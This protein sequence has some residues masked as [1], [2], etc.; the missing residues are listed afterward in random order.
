MASFGPLVSLRTAPIRLVGPATDMAHSTCTLTD[1]FH[2]KRAQHHNTIAAHEL[3]A[4]AGGPWIS[5]YAL[6]SK[7]L[8]A[9]RR[10]AS[11]SFGRSAGRGSILRPLRTMD[12][13]RLQ[14]R[15]NRISA[16]G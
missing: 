4:C 5:F 14:S 13:S 8:P 12:R 10:R 2:R 9:D 11:G 1:R 15:Q 16:C 3:Y 6:N 7:L